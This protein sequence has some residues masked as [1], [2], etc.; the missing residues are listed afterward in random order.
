VLI[1]VAVLAP[2]A[3][4]QETEYM[5]GAGDILAVSVWRHADLDRN[6]V[7]R[8]NGLITFPPVGELMAQGMTPTA[9]GRE[10]TQRLRDY[11]RETNQVTVAMV[12]FNSRAIFL[13]GQIAMPG[14]YSFE[15]VPDI[16]QV[17]SE[18]GGP[19]P[20]ADLS[21]VSV[22]R[23]TTAGPEVIRID[24]GAYMR[25]EKAVALPELRPGD[26]VEFPATYG[27]GVTGPGI[28]YVL[29][30]VNRPGAYPLTEGMDL[31][32]VLAL[33]G[34]TTREAKL[35][36]VVVVMNAGE[37]Q[38]AANVDLTRITRDGTGRPFHLSAGDRIVV[39]MAGSSIGEVLL[40]GAGSLLSASTD[41]LQGY[42]LYLTVDRTLK[43]TKLRQ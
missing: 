26:T 38:V 19:L 20:T 13:T 2:A 18:A 7:V 4:A 33:A 8:T 24:L 10:L 11:T 30:E 42:L 9:L 21:S 14:R 32:Q 37:S 28:V 1:A 34:G 39:P 17:M 40:T 29:G 5:I 36:D 3:T 41:V 12:Q 35:A 15:Q 16:L 27:G 23:P 25:G 22:I 6:V 31:L 43:D